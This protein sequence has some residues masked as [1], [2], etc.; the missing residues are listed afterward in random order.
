[1]D[2]ERYHLTL[3]TGARPVMQGWWGSWDTADGM[4]T[5]WIGKHGNVEAARIVLVDEKE[6]RVLGSWPD[7]DE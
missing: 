3:Y 7:T 6:R 1:M 4:F 2:D 5:L